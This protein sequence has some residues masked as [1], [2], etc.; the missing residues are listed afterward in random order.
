MSYIF[1]LEHFRW[2]D[3]VTKYTEK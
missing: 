2:D 1:R 3:Y